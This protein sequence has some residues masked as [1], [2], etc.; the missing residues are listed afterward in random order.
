[1]PRQLIPAKVYNHVLTEIKTSLSKSFRDVTTPLQISGA[2]EFRQPIQI[3]AV[4]LQS[5]STDKTALEKLFSKLHHLQ[6]SEPEIPE[7]GPSIINL[8]VAWPSQSILD[9]N[10]SGSVDTLTIEHPAA[11][12]KVSIH[13]WW[14]REEY[15]AFRSANITTGLRSLVGKIISKPHGLSYKKDGLYLRVVDGEQK[16]QQVG[17][18]NITGN[19]DQILMFLGLDVGILKDLEELQTWDAVMGYAATCQFHDPKRVWEKSLKV[20]DDAAK[21]TGVEAGKSTTAK[22]TDAEVPM[23]TTGNIGST[24]TNEPRKKVKKGS[25]FQHWTEEYLPHHTTKDALGVY[26]SA[27]HKQII[28]LAEVQFP[29]FAKRYDKAQIEAQS[30]AQIRQIRTREQDMWIAMRDDVIPPFVKLPSERALA[31]KGLKQVIRKGKDAFVHKEIDYAAGQIWVSKLKEKF[32]QNDFD[33]VIEQA[34][35]SWSQAGAARKWQCLAKSAPFYQD[36]EDL[37]KEAQ[38]EK[39]AKE[40]EERKARMQKRKKEKQEKEAKEK[41]RMDD[42][43]AEE[44][45]EKDKTPNDLFESISE[46]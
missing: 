28:D 36:R 12:I 26:A 17:S 41:K 29:G 46:E 11:A 23:S 19:R 6:P 5:K 42:A 34:K 40:K 20:V 1:M 10:A 33:G 3:F 44:S 45:S 22:A 31:R 16:S 13:I 18:V 35:E 8:E 4:E 30:E 7:S 37:R 14:F 15:V 27:T 39:E 38:E 25:L 21:T 32:N 24:A 2:K 9:N 43:E